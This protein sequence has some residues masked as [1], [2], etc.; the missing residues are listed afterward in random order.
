VRKIRKKNCT[1]PSYFFKQIVHLGYT[2]INKKNYYH[3]FNLTEIIALAN[4]QKN[5]YKIITHVLK[6]YIS[7]HE[8]IPI[9]LTIIKSCI[10]KHNTGI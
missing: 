4:K 7:L 9:T 1:N 10:F 3:E 8:R 5:E 6:L 2:I